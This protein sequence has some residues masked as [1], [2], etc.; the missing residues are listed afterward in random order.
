MLDGYLLDAVPSKAQVV[1]SLL[2]DRAP[3]PAAAPFYTGIESL[4][5]KS[6]DLALIALL[7]VLAGK[8]ADDAIVMRIRD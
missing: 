4:G 1:R 5:A 7:V 3:V 8:K 6:P 2:A